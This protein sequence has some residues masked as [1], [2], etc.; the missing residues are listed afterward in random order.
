[1]ASS[2]QNWGR[3]ATCSPASHARPEAEDRI[4]ELVEDAVQIG[5]RVKV[6]GSG[7]SWTDIACTDGTMV[8]L[9]GLGGD[10]VIADDRASVELPAGMRL[11]DAVAFL[12]DHGLALPNL[13]TIVEQKVAGVIGTG[14]HGTGVGIGNLSSFV[15]SLRLVD[16]TGAVRTL[17]PEADPEGWR[18]ARVHLGC[19]G[20]VTRVGLRVVPRF[21]LRERLALLPFEE[22][23]ERLPGLHA[24]HDHV[25]LWWLPALDEV[26]VYTW[27]RTDDPDTGPASLSVWMDQAGLSRPGFA[28]VLAVSRWAPALVPRVQ[29]LVQALGFGPR[30]RVQD[31]PR[32]F[33]I[34]MPPVLDVCEYAVPLGVTAEALRAWRDLVRRTDYAVDFMQEVRFVAGDD[35]ALSPAFGGP[36][37]AIGAYQANAATAPAYFRDFEALM[38]DFGGRPHWGKTFRRSAEELRARYPR[39]DDFAALRERLDPH[40]VFR[41]PFVDRL[42]PPEP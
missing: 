39:W 27:D 26:Q 34:D 30:E 24:A 15:T 21:R 4:V 17:T 29:R 3:T 37:A 7:H 41:S 1:M 16:G 18:D 10:S 19:L 5:G 14:T 36:I 6:V 23:V 12:A 32:V 13:G 25:K 35:I 33:N 11:G 42:F 8:T 28:A 20:V 9:E 38:A 31:A 40:G 22:A 2:W